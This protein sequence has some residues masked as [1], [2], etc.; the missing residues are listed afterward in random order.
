M[1]DALPLLYQ[2]S[3]S[4]ISFFRSNDAPTL[5]RLH[6]DLQDVDSKATK[7]LAT[8][9][10]G[11]KLHRPQFSEDSPVDINLAVRVMLGL[12]QTGQMSEIR[13]RPDPVLFM[14]NIAECL[15]SLFASERDSEI[16]KEVLR[17][18]LNTFPTPFGADLNL[19]AESLDPLSQ[20]L[21]DDA[22]SLVLEIRTQYLLNDL[23]E[24]QEH[25]AFDPDQLLANVFYRDP[26][27]LRG[28]DPLDEESTLPA[29]FEILFKKRITEIRRRFSTDINSPVDFGALE[30]EFPYAGFLVR[31]N[32]WMQLTAR[33]HREMIRIQGSISEIQLQLQNLLDAGQPDEGSKLPM[34]PEEAAA[35]TVGT[36]LPDSNTSPEAQAS[37]PAKKDLKTRKSELELMAKK[38]QIFRLLQ[39]VSKAKAT[40]ETVTRLDQPSEAAVDD[41]VQALRDGE[42]TLQT[43]PRTQMVLVPSQQNQQVRDIIARQAVQSNKENNPTP[44]RA[45]RRGWTDRQENAE[46]LTF[47]SQDD[48]SAEQ[49]SSRTLGKRKAGHEEDE[50]DHFEERPLP[51]NLRRANVRRAPENGEGSRGP[52]TTSVQQASAISPSKRA[53]LTDDRTTVIDEEVD[54]IVGDDE[55]ADGASVSRQPQRENTEASQQQRSAS[56]VAPT[57][58]SPLQ[59]RNDAP[60]SS[61]APARQAS[62]TPSRTLVPTVNQRARQATMLR[63]KKEPQQRRPWNDAEIGRLIDLIK[64]HGISWS[65]LKLEDRNYQ[66]GALLEDRDQVGLKDKARNIKMDFLKYA[67]SPFIM[68]SD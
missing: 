63:N 55:D 54:E 7:R 52:R 41:N 2:Y 38:K 35:G 17:V 23:A 11:F 12:H 20:S 24:K 43:P 33:D 18:L 32:Q 5:E 67:S 39:E 61:S 57:R 10:N 30:K 14:A 15:S 27:H 3:D 45:V 56:S 31:L 46:R 21:V 37:K 68:W 16:V 42:P 29:K 9:A 22:L 49:S 62:G 65:K 26:D 4:L 13:F 40:A 60:P 47:D 34:D 66:G 19:N 28:A 1:V 48:A 6:H 8:L 59:E 64:E 50:D 44:P 58:R 51:S 25:P 36:H 53:R